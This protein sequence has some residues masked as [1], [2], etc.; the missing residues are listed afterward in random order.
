MKL[1]LLHFKTSYCLSASLVI[2]MIISHV[3]YS[4]E[5]DDTPRISIKLFNQPII[6]VFNELERKTGYVVYFTGSTLDGTRKINVNISN[7]SIDQAIESILEGL[8]VDWVIRG[9]SIVLKRLDSKSTQVWETW[10]TIPRILSKVKG[11]I[12]NHERVP[13]PGATVVSKGAGVT[14]ITNDKGYFEIE[15]VRSNSALIITYVGY[16]TVIIKPES[17]TMRISMKP[18]ITELKNVEIVSTGYQDINRSRVTGSFVKIDNELFNRQVGST[19]LDRISN[20]TSGLIAGPGGRSKQAIVIRGESTYEGNS[21]PLIVVDN[22]PYEGS[23][24]SLNPNDVESITVLKDAAAAAVWGTR[25]GNGVIVITTKKGRFNSKL[26]LTLNANYTIGLKPDI[27]YVPGL[28]GKGMIEFEKIQFGKGLY[29][30]YDELYPLFGYFPSAPIAVEILLKAKKDGIQ[31][32]LNSPVVQQELNNLAEK[33]LRRDVERFMLRKPSLQQYAVNITGG[34]DKYSF[35]GSVGYD[36]TR[37]ENLRDRNARASLTWGSMFKPLKNLEING[38][39]VYT[40]TDDLTGGL[41]S[42]QIL[43]EN[44][45]SPYSQLVDVNGRNVVLPHYYRLPYVDTARYP[46][47]LDWHYRPMDEINLTENKS[48]SEET[49][50]SAGLKYLILPWIKTEFQYQ[51]QFMNRSSVRTNSVESFTVRDGIN[52]AMNFKDGILIY[53]Y[54]VGDLLETSNTRMRNWNIRGSLSVDKEWGWHR[55]SGMIGLEY[56]ENVVSSNF[57][58]MFGYDNSTGSYKDVDPLVLL[59]KRPI[60]ATRIGTHIDPNYLLDRFGSYF[61]VLTYSYRD[62]YIVTGSARLDQSNNFGIDANL[63]RVPLWSTGVSWHINDEPWFAVRF[64]DVLKLRTS[65]GFTGNTIRGAT[66][67]PIFEYKTDDTYVPPRGGLLWGEITRPGNPGLKWE[68]VRIINSG[69]DFSIKGGRLNGSIEYFTKRGLD[70]LGTIPVDPTSGFYYYQGNSA[71]MKGNGLD[72]V[73]NSVNIKKGSFSWNSRL[74]FSTVKDKVIQ[75][76]YPTENTALSSV[77]GTYTVG[78][79]LR[80]VFSFKWAGLNPENGDPRVFISDTVSEYNNIDKSKINDL[81]FHGSSSPRIFGSFLNE[82][83]WNNIGLSFNIIYRFKYYFRRSSVNYQNML[84]IGWNGH[85]DFV[86]RWREKGD[87]N[88]TDIPSLPDWASPYR[89]FAYLNSSI[90]VEKGDHVRLQDARLSYTLPSVFLNR[91]KVQT[92]NIYFYAAN[93]GILWRA[94]NLRIDPDYFSFRSIPDAKR[95]TLG[96]TLNY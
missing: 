63:R 79:P 24:E 48:N 94:N 6:Q 32:P 39:I 8:G 16:E 77:N 73:I 49:R 23:L 12:L 90:L 14:T 41:A 44:E 75:Y 19:V 34:S 56:R 61:S 36:R 68:K 52:G 62:R 1:V 42:N 38:Q 65:Y 92:L 66:S 43:F 26:S 37:T 72:I 83:K 46:G 21:A 10:D 96:F 76:N 89:E 85:E 2:L 4:N 74:L 47:L 50:V 87:E 93:L 53:P 64:L 86:N 40:R 71:S 60:G 59:P 45:F 25:A 15:N 9:K 29:N 35:Y 7:V 27:Y 58:Q 80:S 82:F 81:Q 84:N 3:A 88:S 54:P 57:F 18:K 31:E 5:I 91:L 55:L 13:I 69:F 30:A 20:V 33:D 78:Y 17:V 22:F 11:Y 28:D 51:G 95:F 70:L 67:Y